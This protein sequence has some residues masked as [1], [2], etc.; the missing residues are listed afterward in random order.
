MPQYDIYAI[1]NALVDTEIDVTDQNLAQFNIEKG[2]MTLV[3]EARQQELTQMLSNHLTRSKKACGGSAC[4]STVGAAY[5]GAK[6]FFSGKLANDDNGQLF[7]QKL[8]QAD[9]S[10]PEN[11]ATAQ[12][13]SGKCLVMITPDAERTMNTFLG[14]SAE[15]GAAEIDFEAAHN[16][17]YIYIEGFLAAS[18][19]ATDAAI[20]LRE[21]TQ[22]HGVKTA[23][24]FS[25]PSM[26]N[27]CRD[28]LQKMIGSG[29]DLL[30]C[31][32]EE[33]LSFTGTQDLTAA[34]E[35]L[36]NVAKQYV[37]TLGSRGA[38]AFDGKTLINIDSVAVTAVDSNGAGDLFAGAFLFAICKDHNFSQAGALACAAASQLVT[39]YGPRLS[40]EQHAEIRQ[41]V[42]GY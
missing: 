29:V 15:F 22:A 27:Y 17:K 6:T 40:P 13:T 8:E 16:A 23:L 34:G 24:T 3:D 38:V 9:V 19:Q 31:N 4:N 18:E 32:E 35:A 21:H 2:F 10:F 41:R 20:A 28:G 12:G 33:A 5:F 1:G 39:Q 14:I 11:C 42:L 37:I 7:R 26:V 25:D 36:K 30:F